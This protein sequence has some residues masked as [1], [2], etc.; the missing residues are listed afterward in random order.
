[1]ILN[2]IKSFIPGFNQDPIGIKMDFPNRPY[3]LDELVDLSIDIVPKTNL[4]VIKGTVDLVCTE[5]FVETYTRMVEVLPQKGWITH[6]NPNPIAV[7]PKEEIKEFEEVS[8][9]N[10]VVFLEN[11]TLCAYVKCE[12][13][14][15]LKIQLEKSPH[16]E[17]GRTTWTISIRIDIE[18]GTQVYQSKQ[19]P[20][21]IE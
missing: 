11:T 17:V 21:I 13:Y 20:V 16:S 9:H 19:I 8:I 3:R 18:D 5:H 10:R 12:Y 15:K 4:H 2:R 7:I 1:M 6:G 14:T